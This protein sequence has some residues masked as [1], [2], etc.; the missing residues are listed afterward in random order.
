MPTEFKGWDY[1]ELADRFGVELENDEV[2]ELQEF[3]RGKCPCLE[4]DP[5]VVAAC[6]AYLA[7]LAPQGHLEKELWEGLLRVRDDW[8][9]MRHFITL[10]P[11][12]W[13]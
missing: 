12:M 9:F 10:L 5:E 4:T 11:C 6:R 2:K 1:R 8:T 3:L 13:S 7:A